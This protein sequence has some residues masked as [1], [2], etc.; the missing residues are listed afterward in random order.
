M[1]ILPSS[2]PI[3]I[4]C[5]VQQWPRRSRDPYVGVAMAED[6]TVLAIERSMSIET[7]K[8][9]LGCAM[10]S[11]AHREHYIAFNSNYQLV[12]IDTLLDNPKALNVLVH[13]HAKYK[14]AKLNQILKWIPP[15]RVSKKGRP[16]TL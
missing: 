4:F 15:E 8:G 1:S 2:E 7:L 12:W 6:G 9:C 10:N 13:N 16:E 11:P 5:F 3:D 14:N